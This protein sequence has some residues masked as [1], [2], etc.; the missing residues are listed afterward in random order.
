MVDSLATTVTYVQYIAAEIPSNLVI[1]KIGPQRYIPFLCFCSC[2]VSTLQCRADK[3]SGLL[4]C[5]LFLGL[6]EG[7]LFPGIIL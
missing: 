1:K 7:D 6:M 3:Y 4:A 2:I 5:R